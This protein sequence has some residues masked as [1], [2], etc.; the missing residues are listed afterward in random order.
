[1]VSACDS[2][3]PAIL[4]VKRAIPIVKLRVFRLTRNFLIVF[5]PSE[6]GGKTTTPQRSSGI[7]SVGEDPVRVRLQPRGSR[8]IPFFGAANIH[9]KKPCVNPFQVG[10]TLENL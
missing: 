8:Q 5:S 4:R 7:D 1:M 10:L 2:A 6:E 9:R 3:T